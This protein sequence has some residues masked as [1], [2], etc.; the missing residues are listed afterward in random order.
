MGC[1]RRFRAGV[2][3]LRYVLVAHCKKCGNFDLQ[4]ISREYVEGPFAPLFRLARFRAY[5]CE[6][7][8]HKFFSLLRR[9]EWLLERSSSYEPVSKDSAAVK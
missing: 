4:R 7:C 6:P 5:R 8:R 9:R 1:G 2:V 3:P